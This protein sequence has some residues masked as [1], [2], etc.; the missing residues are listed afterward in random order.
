[1]KKRATVKEIMTKNLKS[2]SS[3]NGTIQMAKDIME[4][5]KIRHLPVTNG[6]QLVGI[7]SLT[8]ILRI[9]YGAT[10]GQEGA[11]DKS[12]FSSLSLNQV[13]VH[14]PKTITSETTIKDAA[15]I[16]AS[17]E[18]HALPVVEDSNIEGI[19][20]STDLINYLIEQY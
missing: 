11:V 19:V 18:F 10:F 13:M 5:S 16:L 1:M 15:E 2:I 17:S 12:I 8:D 3:H 20:T 9:S 14:N 7:I 4:E 6:D